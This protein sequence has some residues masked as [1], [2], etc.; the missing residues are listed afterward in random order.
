VRPQRERAVARVAAKGLT[1]T[2][3]VDCALLLA[4]SLCVGCVCVRASQP[5]PATNWRVCVCV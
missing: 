4:R 2:A 5:I 1:A 3:V